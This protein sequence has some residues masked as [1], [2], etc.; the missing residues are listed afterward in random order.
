M[1]QGPRGNELYF[2][3]RFGNYNPRGV[4]ES[5]FHHSSLNASNKDDACFNFS[6]LLFIFTLEC[7]NS[8]FLRTRLAPYVT[9]GR[10]VTVP[11]FE[12]GAALRLIEREGVT[13]TNMASTMVA[14]MVRSVAYLIT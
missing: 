10:H 13:V 6:Q 4:D 1:R 9:G 7:L 14:I 2:F 8:M 11:S 5:C 3:I 12:A